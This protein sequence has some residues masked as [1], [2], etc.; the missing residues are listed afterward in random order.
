MAIRTFSR[1]RSFCGILQL[2]ALVSIG[3]SAPAITPPRQPATG[4]GGAEAHH[5]QVLTEMCGNGASA[6]WLFEPADPK[7]EHAPLI[8]FNH[9]WA[10]VFPDIYG[11]WISHI[12]KRGNI[13]VYP[14]YQGDLITPP[15]LFTP[16]AVNAV[17]SAII[18]LQ[19][20]PGHVRPDLDKFAI[21]GHS[22]GGI[23]SANMA[24][25]AETS[26]LPHPRAL[27]CVQPGK[28][29]KLPTGFT[30]L[31][32][33]LSKITSDVLL[34]SVAGDRDS[35]VGDHDAKRI[36][37]ESTSV[38]LENKDYIVYRSDEHGSPA[39]IASH[40]GPV[41]P[42]R[43]SGGS[44]IPATLDPAW[45]QRARR[46]IE[47]GKAEDVAREAANDFASWIGPIAVDA[48]DYYGTWK[49]FDALTDA[50]FY[51]KNREY[52]LGNTAQQRY[53]GKWSDGVKVREPVVTRK[54]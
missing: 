25:I 37:Y 17:T 6:F 36:F 18:H 47:Q 4:P 40:I 38:P 12:V 35:I 8:V 23:I 14:Q 15:F 3:H 42:G 28:T 41:A 44:R 39:L 1:F 52:A 13:V 26:G 34:L 21:V 22:M 11:A 33:D 9:G 31:L 51:G 10:A 49:L 29:S 54:P 24:A 50:A 45:R 48:L 32:D 53:M 16:T 20:R 2:M 43:V 5:K 46:R 30:V 27:M 19:T 7:P